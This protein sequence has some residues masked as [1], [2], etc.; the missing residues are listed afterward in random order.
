M[1]RT[2]FSMSSLLTFTHLSHTEEIQMMACFILV[3]VALAS[4]FLLKVS[5][6]M[7]ACGWKIR[8]LGWYSKFPELVPQP[9]TRLVN[10]NRHSV[11][12]CAECRY[13]QTNSLLLCHNNN[14]PFTV[15]PVNKNYN[16]YFM[17]TRLAPWSSLLVAPLLTS[18]LEES[19]GTCVSVSWMSFQ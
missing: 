8:T 13:S 5:K 11:R 7:E 17:V 4:Q 6:K 12:P 10:S 15:L 2:L 3:S 9:L 14:S 1:P 19:V 16:Q 18:F